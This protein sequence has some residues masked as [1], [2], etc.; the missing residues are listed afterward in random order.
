M[1]WIQDRLA[2]V[3]T[4]ET[5]KQ[6]MILNNLQK[7]KIKYYFL[8]TVELLDFLIDG[9]NFPNIPLQRNKMKT[10]KLVNQL[11]NRKLDLMGSFSKLWCN[12]SYNQPTNVLGI[13]I[14]KLNDFF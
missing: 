7:S 3:S 9:G 2:V 14:S 6:Q 12:N 10:R 13:A 1:K 5:R 4:D 11:A 8:D